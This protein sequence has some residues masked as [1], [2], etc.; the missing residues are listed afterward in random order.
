MYDE[1]VDEKASENL[2]IK[3]VTLQ[4]KEIC[5]FLFDSEIVD[6]Y[7]NAWNESINIDENKSVLLKV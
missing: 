6:N 3:F 2:N 5:Q 4:T 7:K 1:T